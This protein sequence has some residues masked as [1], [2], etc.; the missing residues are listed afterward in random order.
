M[1]V[2]CNMKKI[3]M[4]QDYFYQGGIEKV[5]LDIKNNLNSNF[6]VD[7]L[8]IVNKS[9]EEVI[10]LTNRDYRSFFTRMIFGLN[11]YKKYIKNN[12]YDIIHIHCYNAFGLIYAKIAKKYC[13]SVILHAHNSGVDDI[14][15]I[16]KLINMCLRKMFKSDK[17]TY[18]AVSNEAN[19]F[20][21]DNK[22]VI[23]LNNCID[24]NKYIFNSN[25]KNE[26]RKKF[27]IKS[28]EIII[29]HIGRFEK[30]KNHK[31]IVHIF[32]EICKIK[33]NYRL[34]LI[35]DGK[36]KNKITKDIKKLNLDTKVIM[37]NY[38]DDI[39]KLINVFD[40]FLFPSF[41]EGFG[42]TIVENEVNGKYVFISDK[43]PKDTIISNRLKII[44][45]SNSAKDWANDIIN[46]KK[47][48]LQ[49]DS[50]LNI[51]F[52]ISKIEDIYRGLL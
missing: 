16:K 23:V 49:L 19:K 33:D 40:V 45:L 13:Q 47:N 46:L 52:F 5:I 7:I 17:Y 42:I 18:L 6:K 29:G 28:N 14:F 34:M 39:E 44:S 35:G 22:N 9:S 21:F 31:M 15:G 2:L 32:N 51:T 3:L 1:K 37:L 8:S 12:N 26:Y 4:F 48:K 20:C 27:G 38:C 43:I 41:Y 24:Y 25:I 30:Q 10:S 11:K 50:R 36:L